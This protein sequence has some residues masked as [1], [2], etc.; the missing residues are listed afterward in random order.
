MNEEMSLKQVAELLGVSRER[1]Q[2]FVA[3]KQ[4]VGELHVPPIGTRYHTVLRS[5]AEAFRDERQAIAA[6]TAPKTKR[7]P[8]P[9]TKRGIA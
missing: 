2:Q 3:G 7:G 4:L 6:G 5:D 8:V 1:V 9:G